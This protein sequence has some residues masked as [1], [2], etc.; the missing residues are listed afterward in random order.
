[1]ANHIANHGVL[2]RHRRPLTVLHATQ[3]T[4]LR[5]F[6]TEFREL[7]QV[8]GGR[9]RYLSFVSQSASGQRLGQDFHGIGHID[10]AVLKATLAL[11]DYDFM[12]CGP[13]MFMQSMYDSLRKLG[14][15]DGRI[16]AEA[17]G[18][19]SLTRKPDAGSVVEQ[20]AEEADDAIVQFTSTDVEQRWNKGDA[21]LLELAEAHG[22]TP[23][24][25]CRNGSCGSCATELVSGEVTYRTVP[26]AP[27]A[28]D[29]VL[30]CCA[31]PARDTV[32][33]KLAL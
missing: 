16:Q 13:P 15:R 10:T 20:H 33:V 21:T 30:I 25:G 4:E 17:F 1:M 18:P 27:R 2:T 28:A 3:S 7:E 6:A 31:V 8:S 11:D 29:E 19:A 5:A 26:S 24:Y 32:S 14:V 22:L 23:A 9:L 12:L